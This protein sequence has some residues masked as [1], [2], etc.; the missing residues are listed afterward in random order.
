MH[1]EK[2]LPILKEKKVFKGS[3]DLKLKNES[4]IEISTRIYDL[5]N[6]NYN[7]TRE[8]RKLSCICTCPSQNITANILNL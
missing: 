6:F 5:G 8:L 4:L 3:N 1:S 2:Q 7:L